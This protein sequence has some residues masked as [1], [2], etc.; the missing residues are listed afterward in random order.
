MGENTLE[1]VSGTVLLSWVKAAKRVLS[2]GERHAN[3]TEHYRPLVKPIYE[4]E[5]QL[6]VIETLIKERRRQWTSRP[7]P[8][9][10]T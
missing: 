8:N 9:R 4:L 1:S 5:R 7:N 6:D 2:N 10:G 3:K